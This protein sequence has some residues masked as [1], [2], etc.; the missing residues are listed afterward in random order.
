[1]KLN[2]E[3]GP[4]S[5]YYSSSSLVPEEGG[6]TPLHIAC[7]REDNPKV[8]AQWNCRSVPPLGCGFAPVEYT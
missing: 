1:M 8:G 6:R 2:N 3:T 4:P 7:E 5:E